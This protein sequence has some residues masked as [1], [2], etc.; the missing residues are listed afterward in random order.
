LPRLPRIDV[1]V[2]QRCASRW[3]EHALGS[4]RVRSCCL[5]DRDVFDIASLSAEDAHAVLGS[6]DGEPCTRLYL[7]QD[8]AVMRADCPVGERRSR[9]RGM[10]AGS[11][12]VLALIGGLAVA[13][14]PRPRLGP[15]EADLTAAERA[16]AANAS[17]RLRRAPLPEWDRDGRVSPFDDD[18]PFAWGCRSGFSA[19][20][21]LPVDSTE[22][23][24]RRSTA[25]LCF[26]GECVGTSLAAA[27]AYPGGWFRF[28]PSNR[29][30]GRNTSVSLKGG[31]AGLHLFVE[32]TA[33]REFL[34]D[35]DLYDLVVRPESGGPPLLHM[36][37]RAV[38]R[39][40]NVEPGPVCVGFHV[41]RMR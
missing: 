10:L 7:R 28:S 2:A 4:G 23:A 38:Y 36:R 17:G 37:E 8:G 3:E 31:S 16:R 40:D 22:A 27:T 26:N 13:S 30:G 6:V 5:C 21:A 18:E 34:H 35:G 14:A 32:R 39:R 25:T 9:T 41:R 33:P 19:A 12:A 1:A 20:L 11:A 29:N 15:M 24:L